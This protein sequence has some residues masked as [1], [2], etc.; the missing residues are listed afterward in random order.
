[1][2]LDETRKSAIE[3]YVKSYND[4]DI[5]NMLRDLDENIVFRN[6]SGGAVNLETKGIAAFKAQADAAKS[7]FSQREQ[8]ITDLKFD[9]NEIEAEI[10]YRATAA[11]DLP[12]G[13]KRG[14]EIE[15]RGKSIF[16]FVNDKITEI[17]D[18]S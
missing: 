6:I 10:S 16:R 11:I 5:E 4:F 9:E 8:K 15:L 13:L 1:M 14:D 17:E 12:N 18:I 3:N 7:F 2:N